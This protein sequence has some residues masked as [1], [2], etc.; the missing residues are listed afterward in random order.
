MVDNILKILGV[1]VIAK[2][3]YKIGKRSGY[4]ELKSELDEGI[5]F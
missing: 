2:V 4:Q 1:Y 3:V 5:I